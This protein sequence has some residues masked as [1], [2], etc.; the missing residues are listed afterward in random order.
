[1]LALCC[2]V[3][4]LLGFLFKLRGAADAPAVQWRHPVRSTGQL[5]S[6]KWWTLGIVVATGGW[7]FHVGALALAPISLVQSVIAGGLVLLTP[8]ADRLFHVP[9]TRRDWVGVAIT[10]AGLALLA[11]TLGKTGDS[12]H[13]DYDSATL[14]AYVGALTAAAGVCA[15]CVLGD[16]RRAGP[17]LAVGAGLL[18]GGSDVT[19]KAA[20][21]KLIDH[22]LWALLTPEAAAITVLSLIGLVVS[23]R[24]LQL[25]PAV[26]V[27]AITSAAANV[28]T[29]AAGPLVFDEPLPD[30]T[31]SLLARL[32]GFVAV[33]A[34]AVLTPGPAEE[35]A[36][37]AEPEPAPA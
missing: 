24:S 15:V 37:P 11:A 13:R 20:S 36:A 12:A 27:I 10:A 30:G 5:F 23:A 17:V 16:T 9:V 6:N 34:G 3:V 2:A 32:V 26:A 22:W 18:W 1:L 19:I 14:I 31:L 4:G 33:I 25:G 28:V 35:T 8:L 29:I 21:G 7:F